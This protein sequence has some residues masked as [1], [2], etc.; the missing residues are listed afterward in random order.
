MK[1]LIVC[2][3]I[4]GLVLGIASVGSAE[5]KQGD[6]NL[7]IS[8]GYGYFS[9]G[10]KEWDGTYG[11]GMG[12]FLT[13]AVEL[14]IGLSGQWNTF[15]DEVNLLVKPNFYMDTQSKVNPYMGLAVG[16]N[17]GGGTEFAGGAQIGMKQFLSENT[18][19]QYELGFLRLF[20]SKL[21]S[22]TLSIGLGF[23]F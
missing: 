18:L 13:D 19:I 9:E 3:L 20:K 7:V 23:K 4:L 8:V 11:L 1:K 15:G 17:F 12:F 22:L 5:V 10:P 6:K 2:S 16:A 14:N 21:N